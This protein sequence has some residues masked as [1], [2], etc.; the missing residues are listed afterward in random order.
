MSSTGGV[1]HKFPFWIWGVKDQ[2]AW[3][4][5][6]ERTRRDS[7][8]PH[9]PISHIKTLLSYMRTIVEDAKSLADEIY[10]QRKMAP[11][12]LNLNKLANPMIST[13]V[14]LYRVGRAVRKGAAVHANE[15][16]PPKE[17]K[18]RGQKRKRDDE[19]DAEAG[20]EDED[21]EDGKKRRGK[22]RKKK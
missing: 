10:R 20:G 4:E 19:G 7:S 11:V 18:R 14:S 21:D 8:V 6:T 13:V 16:A 2:R 22:E 1:T 17:G 12:R 3:T 5:G 15:E 9:L